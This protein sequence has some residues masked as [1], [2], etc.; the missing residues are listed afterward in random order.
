MAIEKQLTNEAPQQESLTDEEERELDIM[1]TM[2]KNLID[3]GGYEIVEQAENS[4]DPGIILGQFLM[5]LGSQL[6][7]ELPFDVSPRIMFAHGGWVEE[8]SDYLEE[9]YG[10]PRKVM[11]RAEIFI[12]SSAQQMGQQQQAPQG[13]PGVP[14]TPQGGMV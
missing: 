8:I 2:A 12:A 11:D 5:Q 14:P 1:V 9:E 3:D 4:K 13:Q 10:V 7:E 6:G